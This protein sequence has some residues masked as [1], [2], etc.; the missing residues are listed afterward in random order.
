M[1]ATSAALVRL[2]GTGPSRVSLA[3]GLLRFG[4][5]EGTPVGAIDSIQT[6]RSWFWT[7]L[8]VREAGG[9]ERAI[10]GLAR[11]DA[12]RFHAAVLADIA[13]VARALGPQLTQLDDRL[14]R[15]HASSRY[16]RESQAS[17]LQSDIAGA[18][19]RGGGALTRGFLP[20]Q[21][22]EALAR[23]QPVA[24]L[25]AYEAARE[26][27]NTRFVA[28]ATPAVARAAQDV[29]S[30]PPT[31]EQA[32]AI[33]TDEDTTLVL[34]GAGTGKT[35]V[36]TGKI[37]HLVRNRGVPPR[38]ILV[39][40]FN[41]KAAQ[42]IRERLPDDLAG[43]HVSTFHAFGRRVIA[44]V[45]AAPTL[46]KLAEDEAMLP[47]VIDRILVDLLRDSRQS[48]VVTNFI[49]RHRTDYRSQF[50][51]KTPGE[52][53]DHVRRSE[54]RTLSGDLVKSFEEL[55]IAN[56]LTQNGV[57]FR[58]ERSYPVETVTPRHRQYRPDFYLPDHD[59]YIEHFALDRQGRAPGGWTGYVEGV[60]WKR[61]IHQRYGTKLIETYSWQQREGVLRLRLREQLEEAGVTFQRVPIRTLLLELGQ[62]LIS[63][64][65]Q[66]L[67]TFLNHVKTSGVSADT[68][69]ERARESRDRARGEAFLDIFEQVSARYD[70]LLGEDKD[71]HDLINHAA[72]HIR[73]GHWQSPYRYV[74]VD[75]FQDISA[76]RM[77]LLRAL[78]GRGV[79]YFLVGDDWQSIYRFAGSDVALV[80]DCGRYLGHVRERALSRTFRFARGIMEPSTE[81][82]VR[83]P[84]Q[85]QR[86]L[87]PARGVRDGGVTLIAND[88][89]ACGLR[90]ALSDIEACE[91]AGGPPVSVLVLGRYRS[92][93][94]P[95]SATRRGRL[96]LKFSTVHAA[97]GREA[98]YAVVLDLRDARRGFPS[99]HED[100]PLLGLVLPPPPG[101]S[102]RHAEERRLFYVALTRA[103]RG[104]YL[105]ADSQRPSAFVNE[106]LRESPGLR[107]LGEFR[108]DRTPTC[109]RCRT[110][111][112]DVS[113]TGQSMT[114][115]NA[116]FCRYRA[117]RCQA[118]R[119]G[120]LVIS[121]SASRCTNPSCNA[122]PPV[123]ESCRVG[124]MVIRQ[125]RPGRFLGCTQYAS[126]QPCTN[127][128]KLPRRS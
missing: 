114:C 126:D 21:V 67:A 3:G 121:G 78:R 58:Y 45:E 86:T 87:S 19:E 120:F 117:P 66:L 23:I 128:Q 123:C 12:E 103:R 97:K 13:R 64:L 91:G 5:A 39:L 55:E 65:A 41:R 96:R 30:S 42:E 84:A 102:Y 2:L 92:S 50:D 94:G 106:L 119:R 68:L 15:L 107:R 40:A 54:L 22:A 18:V 82:V 125:G 20:T 122:N 32:A 60:G 37:A 4:D 76:G 90:D 109:P 38:Q 47:A 101:G 27:A 57:S 14:N 73:N 79:A 33:A 83:N 44:D 52:Y 105:V 24:R 16:A 85:T 70:R 9:A 72:A 10:G 48:R 108:R 100:D 46:S 8:I 63:W 99:Q 81:F 89:P 80:R 35:A 53:Y 62:W 17:G 77:A 29:L 104:T 43:A 36:I 61:D 56:F 113:S 69:R 71:F 26:A 112:L 51:F 74:L 28:A 124:V 115:L 110:G 127:T 49:T 118:C 116:P 93:Q 6:R 75:E 95:L 31:A 98:D 1:S 111:R 25:E 59:I 34:A 7:R 11:E 88:A